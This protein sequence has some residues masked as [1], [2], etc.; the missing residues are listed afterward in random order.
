MSRP[1]ALTNLWHLGPAGERTTKRVPLHSSPALFSFL[2][3]TTK[4]SSENSLKSTPQKS[5]RECPIPFSHGPL[6]M[7]TASTRSPKWSSFFFF[8]FFFA[9]F[10]PALVVSWRPRQ[11]LVI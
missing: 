4:Q 5:E 11:A 8:A 9:S 7:G 10:S 1:T 2:L 3:G 6:S